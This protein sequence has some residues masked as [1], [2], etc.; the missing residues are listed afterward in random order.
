VSCEHSSAVLYQ[1]VSQIVTS[2]FFVCF[3]SPLYLL[4]CKNSCASF[5]GDGVESAVVLDG[6]GAGCRAALYKFHLLIVR[7]RHQSCVTVFIYSLL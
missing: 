2:L 3:F 6:E 1:V 5:S 4:S 7:L